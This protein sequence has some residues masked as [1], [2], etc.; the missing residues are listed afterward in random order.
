[1]RAPSTR[2]QHSS[3][4]R[5]RRA[6]ASAND[7]ADEQPC[8]SDT[9]EG[10][11][12][13]SAVAEKRN[14]PNDVADTGCRNATEAAPAQAAVSRNDHQ[15]YASRVNRARSANAAA[16]SVVRTSPVKQRAEPFR[17][18]KRQ[19]ELHARLRVLTARDESCWGVNEMRA[20]LASGG[21]STD[22]AR[23]EMVRMIHRL[24]AQSDETWAEKE[25]QEAVE[26]K[27][28]SG[29]P[30]ARSE[31]FW[32]RSREVLRS[33]GQRA[34]SNTTPRSDVSNESDDESCTLSD[35]E[36]IYQL[37][38]YRASFRSRGASHA[39]RKR[40]VVTSAAP[41]VGREA[42]LWRC[43]PSPNSADGAHWVQ[44]ISSCLTHR[45]L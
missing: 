21:V 23:E 39:A 2:R 3:P 19:T 11:G 35:D 7:H 17:E 45:P 33:R 4:W 24:V 30:V 40:A 27:A 31:P 28:Q 42:R 22:G 16:K 15:W 34:G 18:A 10:T 5:W 13:K 43:F 14:V 6:V 25:V 1:M 12:D 38:S 44:A 29:R 20:A 9:N 41:E 26:V 8:V 37:A 36:S 32:A